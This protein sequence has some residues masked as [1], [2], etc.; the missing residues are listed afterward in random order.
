MAGVGTGTGV[1]GL[2]KEPGGWARQQL[3]ARVAEGLAGRKG[4]GGHLCLS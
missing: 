4:Q 2:E 1:A 3:S